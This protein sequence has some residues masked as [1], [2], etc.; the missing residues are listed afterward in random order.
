MIHMTEITQDQYNTIIA[1]LPFVT[2]NTY[3]NAMCDII[4]TTLRHYS[5]TRNIT[6]TLRDIFDTHNNSHTYTIDSVDRILP[7][8]VI[9]ITPPV[10]LHDEITY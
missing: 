4:I 7:N 8:V 1:S 6:I 9:E 3:S 2:H 5:T 10:V